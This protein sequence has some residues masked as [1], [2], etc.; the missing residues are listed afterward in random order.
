ML[1][2]CGAAATKQWRL[3]PGSCCLTMCVAEPGDC[4]EYVYGVKEDNECPNPAPVFEKAAN[5]RRSTPSRLDAGVPFWS[6]VF[7][8]SPA[9]LF[10][11]GRCNRPPGKARKAFLASRRSQAEC[12]DLDQVARGCD[13]NIPVFFFKHCPS[14]ALIDLCCVHLRSGGAYPPPVPVQ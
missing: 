9:C 13:V 5:C 7:L 2:H 6:S 12:G 4:R 14:L 8:P 1:E 11:S 3:A 10:R